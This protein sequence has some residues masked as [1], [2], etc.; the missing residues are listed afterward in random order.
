MGNNL[1][2]G[3]ELFS[4]WK[5]DLLSGT[6]P[7][8][9]AL[10]DESSPLKAIQAGPGRVTTLGGLPG[11]GKTA[12]VMQLMTDGLRLSDELRVLVANVEMA[13]GVLMDRQLSR[14]SGIDLNIIQDRKFLSD[15]RERLKVGFDELE[16]IVSRL[17]FV[18][19]PFTFENVAAA[20]D[21]LEP[22]ILVLD[23]LQRFQSS[24]SS[25]DRRGGLDQSMSL[26]RRFADAG[27]CVFVVSALSRQKNSQGRSGYD[28][29]TLTMAAF[30]DSSEI[31]F[32]TDDA[33]I[34]TTGKEP[35]ERVL[36]HLK[37]RNGECRDIPL[38]F[39]GAVQRFS[40]TFIDDVASQAESWWQK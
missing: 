38:E 24:A 15:H 20:A 31:E 26:I 39:D 2:R 33:Y 9:W 30:R 6:P 1:I 36:K 16:S 23:Y 25:D 18:R 27:S 14:L 3:N 11:G 21:E 40:G 34:L 7:I 10:A 13:P 37:S 32:G 19:G 17:G 35:S 28:A 12:F 4:N 5:R 29:E 22:Q 8:R